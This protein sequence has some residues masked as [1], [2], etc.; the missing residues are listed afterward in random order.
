MHMAPWVLP[1]TRVHYATY[2]A[3]TGSVPY[4]DDPAISLSPMGPAPYN[5]DSAMCLA[6][7]DPAPYQG[8]PATHVVPMGPAPYQS[9]L[10]HVPGTHRSCP[11]LGCPYHLVDL[12]QQDDI[13]SMPGTH[14]ALQLPRLKMLWCH[15]TDP[16]SWSWEGGSTWVPWH[17][18]VSTHVMGPGAEEAGC[19]SAAETLLK[20]SLMRHHLMKALGRAAPLFWGFGCC[21]WL[22][23]VL[24][25]FSSL[26]DAMILC[27]KPASLQ[28]WKPWVCPSQEHAA[29]SS[30]ILALRMLCSPAQRDL[31]LHALMP[32]PNL[33]PAVSIIPQQSSLLGSLLG[34]R[35]LPGAAQWVPAASAL[36]RRGGGWKTKR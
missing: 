21:V 3:P 35:S 29:E 25:I 7:M 12:R 10:C 26:V 13:E 5:D 36:V 28:V 22:G 27:G 23:L 11:V 17:M 19:G 20:T 14:R 33:L 34:Y 16:L 6:P 18:A 15:Q 2:L 30:I 8:A 4:R 31:C 24:Q 1:H 32:L 9:I